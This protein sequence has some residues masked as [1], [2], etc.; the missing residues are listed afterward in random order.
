MHTL[1][2]SIENRA[3][4]IYI[5]SGL[6]AQAELFLRHLPQR[7][8]AIVTDS[9]VA[10]LYLD[11]LCAILRAAGVDITTVVIPAGEEH[12]DW[13]SLNA[14]FDAL[15]AARCERK[16]TLIALGGGVVGDLTGFA[17]ATYLRGVPF[18]Q[19]PTTLLALVD[20][21]VGGKTAINHPRGKNM[22]GA[23]YQPQAVIADIATL[24]TL[25]DRELAAGL[26][27]VIKYG[28]IRDSAFFEWLE[29]NVDGLNTRDPQALA[30]AVQRSC[31]NKAAVVAADERETTG[32]RAT[33]NLGHTFGHAVESGMGY[34]NWL[35]GEAV[36]AGMV[37]A[38]RL[39]Q[40]LDL[41]R[42][43]DTGR[44]VAILERARLP[45]RMPDLG[46]DRYLELMGHDKKVEGGKLRFILLSAIG[47]ARLTADVPPAAL[48]AA[49]EA[50]VEHG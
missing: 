16:T 48:A 30:Y 36:A 38:A 42:A 12:K 7:R 14:I 49:L 9:N 27:E 13:S 24:D 26:A 34:G 29:A 6:L 1:Q 44:I 23:F 2:V 15:L 4:P 35:H 39:S 10:A 50:S 20:S 19:V 28:L 5:G 45:V 43:D 22:I 17:A 37:A 25:P 32:E 8:A 47:A 31:E 41:L 11:P 3:Y 46:T 40:T 33:L 18:M 21:S